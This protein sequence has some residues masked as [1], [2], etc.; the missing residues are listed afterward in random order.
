M[1][2]RGWRGHADELH[3]GFFGRPAR[4]AP[5]AV[6]AR[7]DD[8]FPGMLAA[9]V[10]RYDVVEGEVAALLAAV[11]AGVLVPVVNLVA[12]HFSIAPGAFDHLVQT[13][14]RGYRDSLLDG[15]QVAEAV[16]QH[17]RFALEDEDDGAAGAADGERL[18]ALVKD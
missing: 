7:A 11:L 6:H 14:D 4:F 9:P 5:V 3:I 12:G 2:A 15:V 18:V 16:L 10:A 8:V 1:A 13:D 17:L